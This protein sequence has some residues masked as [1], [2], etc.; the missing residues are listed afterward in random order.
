MSRDYEMA[1]IV[2]TQVDADATIDRYA[3]LLADQ[4]A[5]V[6]NVDR[7]GVR[8]LAYEIQKRQQGDYTFFYFQ[9]DPGAIA[10]VERACRLDEDVLRHLILQTDIP[11]QMEEEEDAEAVSVEEDGD[12]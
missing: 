6:V 1:L 9:A 4:G 12:E 2:D 5:A 3:S 7:W 8:R 10:D 11:P